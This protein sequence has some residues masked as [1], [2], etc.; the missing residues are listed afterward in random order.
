MAYTQA[1]YDSV[2]AAKVA[3]ATGARIRRMTV[4]GRTIEYSDGATMKDL[5]DLLNEISASLQ[6][7]KGMF[8]KAQF[9]SPI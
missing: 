7:Y 2:L 3:L 8:N 5:S 9:G 6:T 4:G 1:D